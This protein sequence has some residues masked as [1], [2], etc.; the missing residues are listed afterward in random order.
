MKIS[1]INKV[2]ENPQEA[3][4]WIKQFMRDLGKD[5]ETGFVDTPSRRIHFNDM[6]DDDALFVAN[7]LQGWT[8]EAAKQRGMK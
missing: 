5:H 1:T 4:D 2:I 6:S 7:E 3:R 8:A